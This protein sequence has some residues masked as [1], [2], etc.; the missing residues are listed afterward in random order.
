[1][2]AHGL[3]ASVRE[4]DLLKS[5]LLYAPITTPVM[6]RAAE[7]WADARKRGVPTADPKQLDCDV[8]LA[9]QALEIG[10]VVVTENPGHLSRYVP[11]LTWSSLPLA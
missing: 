1:M 7:L 2:L 10:A 5:T 8:I 11:I 4:L 6:L 9:S 3:I